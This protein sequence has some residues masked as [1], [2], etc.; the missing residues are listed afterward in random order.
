MDKVL[1]WDNLW[2]DFWII[3]YFWIIFLQIELAAGDNQHF[4][5]HLA[6]WSQCHTLLR[7]SI[8]NVRKWTQTDTNDRKWVRTPDGRKLFNQ[9]P[10]LKY[11]F[12][13]FL[14]QLKSIIFI[15]FTEMTCHCNKTRSHFLSNFFDISWW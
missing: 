3:L 10:I 11:F 14:F 2:M 15:I 13:K 7:C 4:D 12:P 6:R 5:E 8:A 1:S 9:D